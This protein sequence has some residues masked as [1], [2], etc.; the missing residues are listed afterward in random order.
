MT[1]AQPVGVSVTADGKAI[2]GSQLIAV[3]TWSEANRVP[4]ARITL[5]DGNPAS[6]AFPLSESAGFVPGTRIVIA[7]GYGPKSTT[8]HSGIV[9]RHSLKI[10]PG[11]KAALVVETADPLVKMTLARNSGVTLQASDK[12]LIAALLAANGGKVGTNSAGTTPR[13]A[14]VQYDAS[15]WDLMLL[16]AEASGCV[17]LVEDGTA[18]IVSPA[19]SSE[20]VLTIEYGDAVVSLEATIDSLSPLS[21]SAAK[22]RSWSYAEQKTAEGAAAS[23]DVT[24]PG[25]LDPA[26][27]AGVFSVAPFRQQAGAAVAAAELA[28]WSAAR[29]MRSKLAAVQGSVEFQGSAAAKPGTFVSLAG[30]GARFNGNAFVAS[31]R[32]LIRDGR[33]KTIAGFG[34]AADSFASLSEGVAAP[35]AAGLM[36]PIRGLHTGLVKQVA[37]DPAGDC[38]VLVT[39]P[40][41]G[42]EKGVWARLGQFYAS[43]GFGAVFYPEVGDEVVLG[44]MDEDP[45]NPVILGSLYSRQR[46]PAPAFPPSEAN[47]LKALVTRSGLV[48]SFD[49]KDVVLE[50]TTPKGRKIRLDDKSGEVKI[51][52]PFNNLVTMTEDKVDI[53]SGAALSLTSKTDMTIKAGKNLTVEATGNYE[54]SAKQI[55]ATAATALTLASKGM[56]ELS[57]K[58]V[59]TVKGQPVMIN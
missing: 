1:L 48:I 15:D 49:D 2:D 52:D 50:I 12:D 54:L 53:V 8:I 55:T 47:D 36:P 46:A 11:A 31:V 27:L 43:K 3:E 58:A 59:L 10:M 44:F 18:S 38:R 4:R 9:V 57:A 21:Q 19:S 17:V 29:L 33:W 35:S 45:A 26:K 14:I 16:R 20:P 22:S 34:M 37:V 25:N 23:A 24:V 13:E 42:D 5:A 7:A 39:L 41:T 30:L 56:G 51:S 40:L 6:K 32:H 28:D